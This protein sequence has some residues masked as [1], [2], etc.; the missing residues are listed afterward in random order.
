MTLADRLRSVPLFRDLPADTLAAL[1]QDMA[2]RRLDAGELLFSQGDEGAECFVILDGSLEV[3][4][5]I[6]GAEHRLEIYRAGQ[7][8]GEM[9]LIDRSP[10]SAS[11]RALEF[12]TLL[13]LTEREFVR[14]IGSSPTMALAMLRNSTSRV[15]NTNQRM[16][17]DLE[18]KNAELLAAYQQL[19]AAQAELIRLNRLEEELAVA[20]RIQESFLPR[21]LPQPPGWQIAAFS[22]GAQAVGGDFYDCI[23]LADGRLGLVVAD[24]CGKGVTAALFVALTRSLLRAASLAPTLFQNGVDQ[25]AGILVNALQLTNDYICREH[26]DS[27]M[28]IT[29]FYGLLNLESG[30][31]D[32]VNAGHNPPLLLR[33]E[34]DDLRELAEGTLPIGILA[35]QEYP[36]QRTRIAPG[37]RLIAFSDGITE[38]MNAAGE[39]FDDAR[40]LATIREHGRMPAAELVQTIVQATETHVAGAPQADD[41]TLLVVGRA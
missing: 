29:L 6:N 31:L 22:C 5:Y 16:I 12:S 27:N 21:R 9:A 33:A 37:D 26:A 1:M 24:A 41:M 7:I 40:L 36:V 13:V 23:E 17:G 15:R 34:D 35:H 38:A 20:R 14:L 32:Y 8:I 11:V 3:L 25:N 19:Q 30:D 39:L 18:R 10:R 2:Q 4:T 28:F